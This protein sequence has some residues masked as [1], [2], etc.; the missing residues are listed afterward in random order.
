MEYRIT[1]HILPLERPN[2]RTQCI[3]KCIFFILCIYHHMSK[4]GNKVVK[5]PRNRYTL[6]PRYQSIITVHTKTL[7]FPIFIPTRGITGTV[8]TTR[9]VFFIGDPPA[10]KYCGFRASANRLTVSEKLSCAMIHRKK[11]SHAR[12]INILD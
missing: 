1:S 3:T 12:I 8:K 10:T 9:T 4:T 7:L 2:C 5:L 11:Q 6:R